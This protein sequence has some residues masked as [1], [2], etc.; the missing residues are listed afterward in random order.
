[1]TLLT[2]QGA[3]SLHQ[4]YYYFE[5]LYQLPSGRTPPVL[6]SHAAAHLLLSHVDEAK[7]DIQEAIQS[8]SGEKEGDVLAVATSLGMEGYAE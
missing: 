6:A 5:E 1:M 2:R 7:A 4:S 3:R 8:G